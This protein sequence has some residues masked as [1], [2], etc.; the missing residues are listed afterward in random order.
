M[1]AE[2]CSPLFDAR[3]V[4]AILDAFG[5]HHQSVQLRSI[6]DGKVELPIY[7]QIYKKWLT[8]QRTIGPL[9][10]DDKLIRFCSQ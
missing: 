3:K 10:K 2:R 6:S 9:A 7:T 5:V 8:Q 1:I 4:C